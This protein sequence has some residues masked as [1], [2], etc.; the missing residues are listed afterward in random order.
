MA[1][2]GVPQ[3]PVTFTSEENQVNVLLLA[4]SGCFRSLATIPFNGSAE[5]EIVLNL[6]AGE[7]RFATNVEPAYSGRPLVEHV[8]H[9]GQRREPVE[10]S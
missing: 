4:C 6:N 7:V 5:R 9:D 3:V 2:G 1:T 8:R 10:D